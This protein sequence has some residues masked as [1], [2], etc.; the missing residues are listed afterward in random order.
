MIL[1]MDFSTGDN[2]P[3]YVDSGGPIFIGETGKVIAITVWGDI[4]CRA[5]TVPLRLETIGA[6]VFLEKFDVILP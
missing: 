5:K 2:G 3:C 6:R 1:S 4:M